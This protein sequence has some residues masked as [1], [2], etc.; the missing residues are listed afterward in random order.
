MVKV[1]DAGF[2]RLIANY[3]FSVK[4]GDNCYLLFKAY[5]GGSISLYNTTVPGVYYGVPSTVPQITFYYQVSNSSGLNIIS[6]STNEYYTNPCDYSMGSKNG[7]IHVLQT[8]SNHYFSFALDSYW[9]RRLLF[10][11]DWWFGF[12]Q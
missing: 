1:E 8:R 12:I 5:N 6:N 11:S 7:K 9:Y 2:G 3:D 4:S 10:L